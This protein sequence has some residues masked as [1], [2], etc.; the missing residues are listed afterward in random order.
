MVDPEGQEGAGDE[1]DVGQEGVEQEELDIPLELEL[2]AE[3]AV[4][5][6]RLN[7]LVIVENANAVNNSYLND[8]IKS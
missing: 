4:V 7:G 8:A 3:T 5:A 2:E 6:W 1:H